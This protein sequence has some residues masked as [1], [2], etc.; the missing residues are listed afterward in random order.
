MFKPIYKESRLVLGNP[1]SNVGIVSLWTKGKK[2]AEKLD[3]SRYA[4][5][6][7]LFSAER[8][9]DV[10]VRNMLANPDINVIVIT[11]TDFSHS[12]T[13]LQDFFEKGFGRGKKEITGK[14]CWRVKSDYP[15]Y[16]EIDIPDWAIDDLRRTTHVVRTEEIESFDFSSIKAPASKRA[17]M[18][19]ERKEE[20]TMEYQGENAVYVVRHRNVAGAWLQMLDTIMK[21]GVRCG[22]HYDD[23]Q[24]EILSLVSI[25][26]DEDPHNLIIPDFLPCDRKHVEEYIPKI[27]TDFHESGTSYT[28]G[29]RIRSW[30]GKDQVKEAVA[31]LVREPNSRAVVISLWDSTQ[32]LTIGGS[33]CVNHLW[34]RVRDGRL[35]LITTI[36]SNDIFEAY[37]ENAYGLRSL[38]EVIRNDLNEELMRSGSS[39]DILLGDL[40]INSQSA[41][42]YDDCFDTVKDILKKHYD[43]YVPKPTMALDPR[44]SFAIST[45]SGEIFAE[46]LSTGNDVI[47]IYRGKTAIE[48]RDA[49]A[50]DNVL[51]STAH[52]LYLGIELYKAQAALETGSAYEQDGELRLPA[53][54]SHST[55]PV[56]SRQ[57][58]FSATHIE[59]KGRELQHLPKQGRLISVQRLED[60]KEAV[61]TYIVNEREIPTL[62]NSSQEE[63]SF[64]EL[65]R[66]KGLCRVF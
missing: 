22:T 12:G 23:E 59:A 29:S 45:K 53:Q 58:G 19:F 44:G 8:G 6:G 64:R 49:I 28:Y 57:G 13:V 24:K 14:E 30:F 34:L 55:I 33:P 36:R 50:K 27:T 65:L 17:K 25:I 4:V 38:Q 31:K 40:V 26:T 5:I 46:H 18:F 48:V 61:L 10:F 39:G 47:G 54:K 66:T 9:L 63:E 2:I 15:G 35:N 42:I 60:T 56:Y 1:D 7:Q 37:P 51:G 43:K 41:H 16:I 32:D 11:G 21:F 62:S 52:A 20:E 3:S